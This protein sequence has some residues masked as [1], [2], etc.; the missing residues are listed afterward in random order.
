MDIFNKS[1][2]V[3]YLARGADKNCFQSF[4][5]FRDSYK[6]NHAGCTHSFYIIFKGFSSDDDLNK[7][8][9]LFEGIPF[10]PVFLED[11]KFD[12]GAYIE[13]ANQ[14]NHDL[15]C[16]LNTASEI[17]AT[18][19]L[20]KLAVN[21]MTPNMGLVGATG[22][23]ESLYDL[24]PLYKKFPS[25]HIRS[26][27]F[28]ID[29]ALFC[30]ITDGVAIRNKMD[31][32][33][34]ESGP[35]SITARIFNRGKN[36]LIVGKN[37][38][39]YSTEFWPKSG[40]FRQNQQENLLVGDNQTRDF[41]NLIPEQR[42]IILFKTWG[43]YLDSIGPKFNAPITKEVDKITEKKECVIII[44]THKSDMS[45][46]EKLSFLNTLRVLRD[47]DIVL[48][49]PLDISSEE[50]L[51]LAKEVGKSIKVVVTRPGW[52]GS[53]KNYNDMALSPDF[54][55][56]F[57][58]YKYLLICHLDAW[59]FYDSLQSWIDKG[60]DYIGAP[61]FLP[62][63]LKPAPL[64][65][66]MLPRGGNGGLSL[67]NIKKMSDLLT[68]KHYCFNLTFLLK[69]IFF[70][71]KNKQ[72]Q[73]LKIFTKV[74]FGVLINAKNYQ[75]KFNIYEDAMFSVFYSF[76]NGS[77]KVCPA[78]E[79]IY[80]AVEVN[81]EELLKTKLKCQ[82]PFGMHGYDKYLD[83]IA[84]ME[85]FRNNE[86]RIE[87]S[88]NMQ[89]VMGDRKT[90]KNNIPLITI[91]TATYNLIEAGR[92]E[93]FKR[94]M[95][96]IHSQTYSNIEHIIIDGASTDGTLSLI[97][98]YVDKGLCICHSEKD[99]GIWDAMYK[100]QQLAKG[101]FLNIMNSDD[102][103]SRND[104]VEIA[105]NKLVKNRADWFYSNGK[106]I[107]PDG[108]GYDFPTALYGVFHCIGILHQ[109]MFIRASLL[110]AINPFQSNHVTREN[111]LMMLLIIN[112]IKHA[113]SNKFLVCYQEG[114]FSSS[115]YGGSNI[116]KTKEDFAGYCYEIFGRFWGLTQ[117]DCFSLFC[118][119]C[120]S[121]KGIRYSY[122]ISKKIQL[123]SY[124]YYFRYRLAV[125]AYKNR[126]LMQVW[127]SFLSNK[128]ESLKLKVFNK[129]N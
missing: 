71:I 27:A 127:D 12:L 115:E 92:V 73:F 11:D 30:S 35:H 68:Q 88:K 31:A 3:A 42:K 45:S 112:K 80:F 54:Y 47:W 114:G 16:M 109:T 8:V 59:I 34:L 75:K 126:K 116:S 102:Y 66:A 24:S 37:G 97:Q 10:S 105:V 25:P 38:R 52:L 118:L 6:N 26:N 4:E 90:K 43:N 19:W 17:Q 77:F 86:S 55:R 99:Q 76:L 120:F 104:A 121:S 50:Y 44:P 33:L 1:I 60:Y 128:L 39:G 106:I 122:A 113:K 7:A 91:I 85:L 96:S 18:D 125:Y 9:N 14:I 93:T 89:L 95:D 81:A 56:I 103:F 70:L 28:M 58:G 21:L 32:L 48:L 40:T 65:E 123:R 15:I 108:S 119:E 84:E 2:A 41:L 61:W 83:S 20:C 117:D 64:E 101:E 22:S 107:R 124:R 94:C 98:D 53:L 57:E 129:N 87:Y 49:I 72:F 110:R 63:G 62:K 111:Y 23:Y 82:L 36:I 69:G 46:E 13:W 67:R 29:R 74:C 100:G 78:K 79:A 51:A 5:R